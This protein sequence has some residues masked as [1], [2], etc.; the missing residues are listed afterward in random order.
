MAIAIVLILIVIASV[1]FHILAPWHATP[2][3][4]NWGSIDT[5]L[6]ITLIISGI[7]F[8]AITVFM[9]LAVM[10]YRHKEGARA[11]YQPENK[12]LELWLIIITSVG[13][14]GMLAPGL[15]VY[16]DFIRVPKE[17]YE[18][19]VVAQQWQWAFRF[20]GQDAKLGKSDIRFI[21]GANPFGL[22]PKDPAG[23]DD[24]LVL[25]NEVRLPLDRPVKVLLR[26][27]D[28]LHDF[29]VPQ[30][31]SKMDM[32]PG[33]VSYFWFT[34]TKTGKYEVLCAE[35]CGVGHYNMRGHMIVE[36]Q[37]VFDQWL[38]GQP[39]FAQTLTTTAKPGRDSVLEKGRQLVEQLGCKACHSQDGSA[40]LG[41]GWKGLY[42]RTEQFADG[43]SAVV[44]EAYLKES[45]LDP[46]ARL[47]QG[48]PPVMVAYTLKDDELGAV[49]AL[50]KS[51]GAAGQDDEPST[52]EASS[53]GEDLVAQGQRLAGSLG[54]LA[55]HSVDGNK[56]V[57]P[58]WQGLYG[59]TQ[60]LADDTS[61]KVDE[62]YIK[63]SVLHPSAKIVKGY[64]A[65]MPALAP[66]D[67]ELN[68]LI[69]F[70]KS[71]ANADADAS[72]AEPGK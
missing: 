42:G 66:S 29:Y 51:L 62:G 16:N 49:I 14:A 72:K 60:T 39:T 69:A 18:L 37:G 59:K 48:Y 17:A 67:E 4:S 11:A 45:I 34:P 35:F 13:I 28:V 70:I 32:V 61:V 19:E 23:Q 22:D 30:I 5:T 36:E 12:K 41:P 20:P 21:D 50:I 54:C 1:L 27:K 40:S 64:A 7:F 33:M 44:D 47:V 65:V 56:G 25:N 9:A 71:I 53:P 31:R 52:G 15:V 10:R 68:A 46:K 55:C 38:K 24:V 8:I 63:E 57:G 3:A 43:T 2:A 26:A 6:F 58:S